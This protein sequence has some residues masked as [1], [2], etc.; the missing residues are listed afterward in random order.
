MT[1][2]DKANLVA[3]LQHHKG[4]EVFLDHLKEMFEAHKNELES[5][6]NKCIQYTQ[7]QVA[8]YRNI[9]NYLTE[10]NNAARK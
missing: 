10:K 5:P 1:Q 3:S 2:Q 9:F 8:T 6:D 4:F 7:G